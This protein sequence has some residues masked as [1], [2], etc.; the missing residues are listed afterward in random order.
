MFG[1]IV[2]EG[3]GQARYSDA[4]A[5]L[6]IVRAG[7]DWI[8]FEFVAVI[9]YD[10]DRAVLRQATLKAAPAFSRS[11]AFEGKHAD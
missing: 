9:A 5:R 7:E 11:R 4:T 6:R 10:Y 1:E 2:F 3:N 8:V